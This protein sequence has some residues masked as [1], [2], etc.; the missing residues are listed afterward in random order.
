MIK[1]SELAEYLKTKYKD[2]EPYMFCGNEEFND[3]LAQQ[4]IIV[5]IFLELNLGT[6]KD[7]TK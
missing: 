3:R 6:Y 4:S 5:D 2:K 1:K 7:I